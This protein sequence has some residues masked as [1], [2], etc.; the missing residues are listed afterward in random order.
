ME[1]GNGSE[2]CIGKVAEYNGELW[3][4]NALDFQCYP[5]SVVLSQQSGVAGLRLL[6]SNTVRVYKFV[7]TCLHEYRQIKVTSDYYENCSRFQVPL[8]F[9]FFSN[10]KKHLTLNNNTYIVLAAL[11]VQVQ[12]ELK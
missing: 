6:T 1:G 12:P 3:L 2:R 9:F 8:F 7:S 5:C 11:V 4:A 10:K